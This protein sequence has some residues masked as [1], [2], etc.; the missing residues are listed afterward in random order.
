MN[1]SPFLAQDRDLAGQLVPDSVRL[2]SAKSVALPQ[3]RWSSRTMEEE[4]RFAIR[5]YYVDVLRSMISRVNSHTQPI[6]T[7]YR[8][9]PN[10]NL[11]V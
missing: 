2:G 1:L 9:H 8:W 5:A 7:K 11:S 6:K 3:F 4:H 10:I